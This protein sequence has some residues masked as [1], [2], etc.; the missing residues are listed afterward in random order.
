MKQT[1]EETPHQVNIKAP[2]FMKTAVNGWFTILEAQFHLRNVTASKTKFY[3][4][5]LSLPSEEVG[6]LPN[7]ILA[8][9]DY[10]ELKRT[11]IEAHEQTKPELLEKINVGYDYFRA[12]VGIFT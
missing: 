1:G 8:S 5:I 3:A 10:E 4:V 11:L 2:E 6:N 12:T 9:Q 7:A